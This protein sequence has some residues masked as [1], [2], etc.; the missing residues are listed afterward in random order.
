VSRSKRLWGHGPIEEVSRSK[1][2][3]GVADAA[4]VCWS[5]LKAATHRHRFNCSK[6]VSSASC[7]LMYCR[8]R[9]WSRPTVDT[10]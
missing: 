7:F 4:P 6:R 8:I 2:L 3:H 5:R 1:R 9:S 10:K